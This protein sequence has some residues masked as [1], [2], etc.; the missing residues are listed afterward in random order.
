MNELPDLSLCS[1]RLRVRNFRV[2]D[3]EELAACTAS[4]AKHIRE[5]IAWGWNE[6]QSVAE[7]R[8][9]IAG[10][11]SNRLLAGDSFCGIWTRGPEGR[12]VGGVGLHPR[13]GV[14]PTGHVELGYWLHPDH[15]GGGLASEAT[16][17]LTRA[18]FAVFGYETVEL[19]IRPDNAKSR[20]LAER[21]GF[22][23]SERVEGAIDT[24]LPG[25][26][27]DAADVFLLERARFSETAGAQ[28]AAA[29]ESSPVADRAGA[30]AALGP[31]LPTAG[32][33]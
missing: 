16:A 17:L 27:W 32:G 33:A 20:A 24:G 7:K 5:W 12:L 18:A 6:P 10:F 4:A 11:E 30:F 23:W 15:T 8:D 22:R 14:L 29:L 28:V 13:G 3:A 2:A 31:A 19:R 1:A 25:E 26:P 9:L 21:L